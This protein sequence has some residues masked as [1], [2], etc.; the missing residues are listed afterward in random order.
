MQ[1]YL[2][3][4]ASLARVFL[5]IDA[6]HGLKANDQE[7]MAL[8]D[9]AAVSYMAVLTKTD[10]LKPGQLADIIDKTGSALARHPAAH[11]TLLA[12]SAT[13]RTGLDALRHEIFSLL[14]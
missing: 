10:K 13:K 1:D 6:R 2:R 3:G 4:R 12:T 8:L 5:L 7:I 14:P 9:T 11:P